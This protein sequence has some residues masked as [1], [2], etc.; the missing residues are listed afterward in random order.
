MPNF[1]YGKTFRPIINWENVTKFQYKTDWQDLLADK[2]ATSEWNRDRII[3]ALL[4]II[5]KKKLESLML[6]LANR[7]EQHVDLGLIRK[8]LQINATNL[9]YH[10]GAFI[11]ADQMYIEY[12]DN[13]QLSTS[14]NG[15]VLFNFYHKQRKNFSES[16]RS[17]FIAY[18]EKIANESLKRQILDFIELNESV[19]E[20]IEDPDAAELEAIE[21][22]L[23]ERI[24]QE[25]EKMSQESKE[26]TINT[27]KDL[28]PSVVN[29]SGAVPHLFVDTNIVGDDSPNHSPVPKIKTVP[30]ALQASSPMVAAK[31]SLFLRFAN[32]WKALPTRYKLAAFGFTVLGIAATVLG[33]VFPPS[34]TVTVP[35]L[36]ISSSALLTY[37]GAALTALTLAGHAIHISRQPAKTVASP[38]NTTV[39]ADN[40]P[41]VIASAAE[42]EKESTSYSPVFTVTAEHE[43]AVDN[44]LRSASESR[45][46]REDADVDH[47]ESTQ[48]EVTRS[49]RSASDSSSMTILSILRAPQ[50]TPRSASSLA[51]LDAIP[52]T[53]TSSDGA[54]VPP[55]LVRSSS[56]RTAKEKSPNKTKANSNGERIATISPRLQMR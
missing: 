14:D 20:V 32:K 56:V 37:G 36:K 6:L 8:A 9:F 3:V 46:P 28:L 45:T 49:N 15:H 42:E 11:L 18:V 12:L 17:L 25:E 34:L 52:T 7:R 29:V 50:S 27:G 53:P 43:H 10:T 48:L 51:R 23:K 38:N 47:C 16:E 35:L 4:N 33:I 21:A 22:S 13:M 24:A 55:Q 41:P 26:E 54:Y 1:E 40:L 44:A 19:S 5:E 31:A 39:P 2:V 30:V